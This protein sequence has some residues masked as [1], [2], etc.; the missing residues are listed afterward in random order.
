MFGPNGIFGFDF[1]EVR[2]VQVG[3]DVG[4]EKC[5]MDAGVC[6]SGYFFGGGVNCPAAR[7]VGDQVDMLKL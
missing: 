7:G 1:A 4:I 2:F 5:E 6:L 3:R